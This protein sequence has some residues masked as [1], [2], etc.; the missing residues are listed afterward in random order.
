MAIVI[1]VFFFGV[2]GIA[3]IF[4]TTY[5]KFVNRVDLRNDFSWESLIAR[6][7]ATGNKCTHSHQDRELKGRKRFFHDFPDVQDK[8]IMTKI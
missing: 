7:I 3:F 2:N 8:E 4:I 5:S 1:G 6:F